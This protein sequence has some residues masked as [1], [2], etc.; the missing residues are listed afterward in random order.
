MEKHRG[1]PA[2][3]AAVFYVYLVTVPYRQPFTDTRTTKGIK[4]THR[5]ERND[6]I[7]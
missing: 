7:E 1:D 5:F 6:G 3:I 4:R 2:G